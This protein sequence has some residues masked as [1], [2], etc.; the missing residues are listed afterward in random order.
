[1]KKI[2]LRI[3]VV[4]LLAATLGGIVYGPEL[5]KTVRLGAAFAAKEVCSGVFISGRS[6][7]SIH[8][9]DM[10]AAPIPIW[11]IDVDQSDRSV[12]VSIGPISRT[13]IYREN[14]G[15][16]V[17]QDI[18]VD[19]LRAQPIGA[20]FERPVE[21]DVAEW[22]Q[23]NAQE[24]TEPAE[25]ID[26]VALQAALDFA[27]DDRSTNSPWGTRAVVVVYDGKLV[28]ER[29]ADGYHRDMPLTSWSMT[30]T[31]TAT[32]VGI[33]SGDGKLDIN[34]VANV[35]EW[36]DEGDERAA[37]TLDQLLRMSSGLKFQEE[38]GSAPSDVVRMLYEQPDAAA[39]AASMPLAAEPDTKW[40]YSSGTTNIISRIVRNAIGG[41][42]ETYYRFVRER[43]FDPLGM[44]RATIEADVSGTLVGSS[45]M[46]CTARDWARY[47]QFLM[48]DGVWNGQRIL[49]DGWVEYM[50]TP[51]PTAPQGQYGAQT[52]LNAGSPN[53]PTDR[54]LPDCPTDLIFLS[55]FNGQRVFVI[56]SRQT[57][58]VRMGL[59]PDTSGYPWND[60]VSQVLAA[61]PDG[62]ADT[63]R[64]AAGEQQSLHAAGAETSEP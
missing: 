23:G 55:G 35:P 3:V 45:F 64:T 27:F 18:T 42:Q 34:A 28:A 51:T 15:C 16:T 24:L 14:C 37:I 60:L 38:Y 10:S 58:I 46:F 21:S 22:P 9:S 57:V 26:V 62:T 52:W 13:A 50:S 48:Q 56:P 61:L 2:V 17:A 40:S 59:T 39:F 5:L 11:M 7:E 1:M 44:T 19:Q 32:L 36:A 4:F 29:Y 47:G 41:D 43:L 8:A 63:V 54:R 25:P 12:T 20:P 53:D 30:K 6:L 31:I 33:L 49:P